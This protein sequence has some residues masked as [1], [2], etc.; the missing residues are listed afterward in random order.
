MLG[1]GARKVRVSKAAW[2]TGVFCPF[3]QAD[4][5]AGSVCAHRPLE[6]SEGNTG[7]SD[8]GRGPGL[9]AHPHTQPSGCTR[10]DPAPPQAPTVPP[11]LL[12]TPAT[13]TAGRTVVNEAEM[14]QT[15]FC[16]KPEISLLF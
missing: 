10:P 3:L 12:R 13:L 9:T 1:A 11:T 2:P 8:V 16:T 15:W 6:V 14:T 5:G 4:W 7:G